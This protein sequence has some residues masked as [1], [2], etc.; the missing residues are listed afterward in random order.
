MYIPQYVHKVILSYIENCID[1]K[2]AERDMREE[3]SL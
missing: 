3:I 1:L 2:R